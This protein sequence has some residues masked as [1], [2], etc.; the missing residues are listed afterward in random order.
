MVADDD[1]VGDAREAGDVA[2]DLERAPALDG[3]L[4]LPREGDDA[5]L[6]LHAEVV[7][8]KPLVPPQLVQYVAL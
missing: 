1:A 6:D 8:P 5:P 7:D 3:R 4:G 2:R